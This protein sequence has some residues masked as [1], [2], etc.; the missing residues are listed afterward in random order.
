MLHCW[1]LKL[2]MRL[3]CRLCY[4][5][6]HVTLRIQEHTTY[7][8]WISRVS[9][10]HMFFHT[11][12]LCCLL[13]YHQITSTNLVESL[14]F[15][16]TTKD[17][18][19]SSQICHWFITHRLSHKI[20]VFLWCTGHCALHKTVHKWSVL[21]KDKTLIWLLFFK[22]CYGNTMTNVIRRTSRLSLQN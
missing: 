20:P 12:L 2:N 15:K 3:F 11:P 5:R 7:V 18:T 21:C 10:P 16:T 19:N 1:Y 8:I 4:K 13:G 14:V 17:F 22:F 9:Y 6:T